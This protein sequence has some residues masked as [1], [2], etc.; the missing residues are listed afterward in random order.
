MYFFY[1]VDVGMQEDN[2]IIYVQKIFFGVLE[3][4]LS[5]ELLF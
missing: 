4:Y 1:D 2:M 5:Q 3:R